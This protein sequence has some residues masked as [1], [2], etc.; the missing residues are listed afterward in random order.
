MARQGAEPWGENVGYEG[1]VRLNEVQKNTR[2]P[3]L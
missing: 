1:G 3:E 2:I